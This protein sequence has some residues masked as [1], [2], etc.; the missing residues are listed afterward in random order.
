MDSQCLLYRPAR[1]I[2]M[3][4]GMTVKLDRWQQKMQMDE[5]GCSMT[6]AHVLPYQS[7]RCAVVLYLGATC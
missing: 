5:I 7:G 6:C 4:G 3:T 1:L 2:A